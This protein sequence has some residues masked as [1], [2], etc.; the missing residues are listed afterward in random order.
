MKENNLTKFAMMMAQIQ[1]VPIV[2]SFLVSAINKK[3]PNATLDEKA[4][5]ALKICDEMYKKNNTGLH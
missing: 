3:L 4:F 2:A 5:V 1:T